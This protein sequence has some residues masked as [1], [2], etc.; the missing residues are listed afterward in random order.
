MSAEDAAG[1]SI[2]TCHR[3]MLLACTAKHVMDLGQ[4]DGHGGY[5]CGGENCGGG[6]GSNGFY[7]VRVFLTI[8][9]LL[10]AI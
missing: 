4:Q 6:I 8:Y 7:V 1:N 2:T 3:Q 9:L 5:G 10:M